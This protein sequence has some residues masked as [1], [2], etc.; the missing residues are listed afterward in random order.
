VNSCSERATSAPGMEF[1]L[2]A[3]SLLEMP[4]I[5]LSSARS[6]RLQVPG[7]VCCSDYATR[8]IWKTGAPHFAGTTMLRFEPAKTTT[9]TE[10]Y[11]G[12]SNVIRVLNY[13]PLLE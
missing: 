8:L 2:E 11:P 6:A 3:T 10:H 9:N 12:K 4:S 1:C 7:T 13:S 5:F